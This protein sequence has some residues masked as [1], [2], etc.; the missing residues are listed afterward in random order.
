MPAKST[1]KSRAT[2]TAA[3][4]KSAPTSTVTPKSSEPVITHRTEGKPTEAKASTKVKSAGRKVKGTVTSKKFWAWVGGVVGVLVLMSVLWWQWD[5]SHVAKV[6]NQ[7]ITTSLLDQQN[8]ASNGSKILPQL[9]QQQ[10][11]MQEAHRLKITIDDDKI[12][13]ELQKFK[14]SAGGDA[15][16]QATLAQFGISED[17]LVNQI[18]VRLILE[19]LLKDKI[20]VS[21]EEVQA[22]YDQNKDQIDPEGAGLD[23]TMKGQIHD[24]LSQQK[25]SDESEKYVSDLEG[26]TPVTTTLGNASRGYVA[27]VQEVI[28]SIPADAWSMVAPK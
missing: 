24:Q 16:Y 11:I 8:R 10:L 6:G 21:D 25:L 5:Q 12:N 17:L 27:F 15:E 2:S 3:T 19:E 23:D 1:K 14:D 26:K 20:Q 4:A 13:A 28:L 18:R 22:Y 9:V 7:Y